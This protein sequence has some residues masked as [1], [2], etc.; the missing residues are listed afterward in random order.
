MRSH[1]AIKTGDIAKKKP[2]GEKGLYTCG[3]QLNKVSKHT[4]PQ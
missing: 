2:V 1:L 3:Q 4:N